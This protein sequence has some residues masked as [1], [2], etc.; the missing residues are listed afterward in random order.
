M[1]F[2]S[3]KVC[4]GVSLEINSN[5]YTRRDPQKMSLKPL[6]KKSAGRKPSQAIKIGIKTEPKPGAHQAIVKKY[7]I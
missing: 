7:S 4:S 5:P 2:K 1:R 6:K 3:R